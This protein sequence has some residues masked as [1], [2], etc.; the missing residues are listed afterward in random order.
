[1]LGQ[2]QHSGFELGA[3]VRA[4]FLSMRMNHRLEPIIRGPRMD[5]AISAAGDTLSTPF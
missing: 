2:A 3:L 1:M 4:A 5:I